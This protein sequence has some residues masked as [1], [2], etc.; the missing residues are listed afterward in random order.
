MSKERDAADLAVLGGLP[1][2]GSVADDDVRIRVVHVDIRQAQG[3]ELA[4]A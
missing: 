4:G 3:H 1:R 2:W